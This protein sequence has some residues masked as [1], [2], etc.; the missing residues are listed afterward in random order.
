MWNKYMLNF[1]I[2]ELFSADYN[3]TV[4]TRH[5]IFLEE[6]LCLNLQ[7]NDKAAAGF[8]AN[9]QKVISVAHAVFFSSK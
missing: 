1:V 5:S 9:I 4:S 2:I 8:S 3:A 7:I 6:R